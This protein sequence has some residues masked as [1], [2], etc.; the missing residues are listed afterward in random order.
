[1]IIVRVAVPND[2]SLWKTYIYHGKY[3]KRILIT[4]YTPITRF[5]NVADRY[6]TFMIPT[7][8]SA[9]CLHLNTVDNYINYLHYVD[10]DCYASTT[11]YGS[12]SIVTV[13]T[14]NMIYQSI[15]MYRK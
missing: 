7:D 6:Y 12:S 15:C 3:M 13:R 9:I 1:M 8:T 10:N 4:Q 5:A 11:V 14:I 2:V